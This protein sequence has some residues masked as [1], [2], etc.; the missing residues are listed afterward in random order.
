LCFKA[1]EI[2]EEMRARARGEMP[3]EPRASV[4]DKV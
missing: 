3:E 4:S 2:N 1:T